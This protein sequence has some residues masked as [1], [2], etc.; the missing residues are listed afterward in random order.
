M[1]F[2]IWAHVP[3]HK[4]PLTLDDYA[5][6]LMAVAACGSFED[7]YRL[8]DELHYSNP[9]TGNSLSIGEN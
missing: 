8:P 9:L 7:N 6:Y 1:P 5:D 2:E 4:A 3:G